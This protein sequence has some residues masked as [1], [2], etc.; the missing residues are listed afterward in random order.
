MNPKGFLVPRGSAYTEATAAETLPTRRGTPSLSIWKPPGQEGWSGDRIELFILK[1][2]QMIF[3]GLL[4]H[5]WHKCVPVGDDIFN[6]FLS[7]LCII[8]YC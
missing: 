4:L 8:V 6:R 3:R 5:V 1:R 2:M 7:F